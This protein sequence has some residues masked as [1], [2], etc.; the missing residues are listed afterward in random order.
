MR[1]HVPFQA[2]LAAL[3]GSEDDAAQKVSRSRSMASRTAPGSDDPAR[4][5]SSSLSVMTEI[6][7]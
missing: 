2:P 3:A 5:N 1:A 7:A 4:P 6:A